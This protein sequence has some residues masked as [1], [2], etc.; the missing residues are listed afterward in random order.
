MP[1]RTWTP[2]RLAALALAAS[3][4]GC[5]CE[6]QYAEFVSEGDG[7]PNTLPLWPLS[8]STLYP[9]A[10]GDRPDH[11]QRPL[12]ISQRPT[13]QG[14]RFVLDYPLSFAESWPALPQWRL[15]RDTVE[16][17]QL[18]SGGLVAVEPDGRRYLLVPGKAR[19][20]MRW[21][22]ELPALAGAT[23]L[24]LCHPGSAAQ[25]RH[26]AGVWTFEVLSRQEV[27]GPAG[28][29]VAW[30]IGALGPQVPH[31]DKNGTVDDG[32]CDTL[33]WR[34]T[35]SAKASEVP[36]RGQ[37]LLFYEGVGP[38]SFATLDEGGG[39]APATAT[40]PAEAFATDA[41]AAPTLPPRLPVPSGVTA[42][43]GRAA[44]PLP[45]I[46]L[47]D[48]G[49]PPATSAPALFRP[50]TARLTWSS[51]EVAAGHGAELMLSGVT[52]GFAGELDPNGNLQGDPVPVRVPLCFA[53]DPT[54]PKH[55]PVDRLA[56]PCP[57][58]HP[59][60]S[61]SSEYFK[62]QPYV[63]P[64]GTWWSRVDIERLAWR[65]GSSA[66]YLVGA[67]TQAPFVRNGVLHTLN[68]HGDLPT[69]P[70]EL[71]AFP[72]DPPPW[73]WKATETGVIQG[74]VVWAHVEPHEVPRRGEGSG[75]EAAVPPRASLRYA[76]A[77]DTGFIHA[78]VATLPANWRIS[79]FEPGVARDSAHR[80]LIVRWFSLDGRLL[81]YRA[82]PV[83]Q[84]GLTHVDGRYRLVDARPLGELL[85]YELT[86]RG[87]RVL[88]RGRLGLGDGERAEHALALAD[89]RFLVVTSRPRG[90]GQQIGL[91]LAATLRWATQ[92]ASA[93][94]GI[95]AVPDSLTRDLRFSVT[96]PVTGPA[97]VDVVSAGHGLA[98]WVTGR[99]LTLCDAP[100][101]EPPL[102]VDRLRVGELDVD[103]SMRAR[104]AHGC[105][106][107]AVPEPLLEAVLGAE[108]SGLLPI[109][110]T[111]RSVGT[112]RRSVAVART[113]AAPPPAMIPT[114]P[115]PD[116]RAPRST[117][118][119]ASNLVCTG[120]VAGPPERPGPLIPF[121][122]TTCSYP[123][124]GGSSLGNP[125]GGVDACD[126]SAGPCL[127]LLAFD[128]PAS[129]PAT[130]EWLVSDPE[131]PYL[132]ARPDLFPAG[133]VYL[134]PRSRA[135]G[136]LIARDFE[137][138]RPIGAQGRHWQVTPDAQSWRVPDG[139]G[140][141]PGIDGTWPAELGTPVVEAR[142]FDAAALLAG[143]GLA[144]L[145][146]PAQTWSG[147]GRQLSLFGPPLSQW[148]LLTAEPTAHGAA[149]RWRHGPLPS[150]D[151]RALG[152][153]G[154]VVLWTTGELTALS[155]GACLS[156][157]ETCNGLDDDC[158][159]EVDETGADGCPDPDAVKACRE[160]VCFRTACVAG[161]AACGASP[162]RCD[163]SLGTEANCRACGDACPATSGSRCSP[164]GCTSAGATRFAVTSLYR[165]L[166]TTDGSVY[167][168]PQG[169][170]WATTK[171]LLGTFADVATGPS[172]VCTL[173][174][175]GQVDCTC[176]GSGW[177][178][179]Q[180]AFGASA[181]PAGVDRVWAGPSSTCVRVAGSGAVTC[182]GAALSDGVTAGPPT[183]V[184]ALTGAEQVV[185]S[186]AEGS[187]R[188]YALVGGAVL[189]FG[190]TSTSLEVTPVVGLPTVTSLRA[191]TGYVLFK[192]AMGWFGLGP[193][194]RYPMLAGPSTGP[195]TTPTRAMG[196][197]DA[198]GV[199]AGFGNAPCALKPGQIRCAFEPGNPPDRTRYTFDAPAVV[200]SNGGAIDL[201]VTYQAA[202]ALQSTIC[203]VREDQ[204]ASVV[205]RP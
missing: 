83:W 9:I 191:A 31:V 178:S 111:V 44:E 129:I 102:L 138:A 200:D 127:D 85:E 56:L 48:L 52:L 125:D 16:L 158:D 195:W 144:T 103:V 76:I 73:L 106:Q 135:A 108:A 45:V 147:P 95:P 197:D 87:V 35:T 176:E 65:S 49:A 153:D 51:S 32:S 101:A 133:R 165:Y 29:T 203:V 159:G 137:T 117:R 78:S 136:P 148:L 192:T 30:R 28:P 175:A 25:A 151:A 13:E 100:G 86:P 182:W 134:I 154:N 131:R 177:Q 5:S 58:R 180:G 72:T 75:T 185:F 167:R 20:G 8:P 201:A 168:S 152:T 150:P 47:T 80:A 181:G 22:V 120:S 126:P 146:S 60:G 88:K 53:F 114:L 93:Y 205:C 1:L 169:T 121:S 149:P 15:F 198:D 33:W 97:T 82:I 84:P 46:T 190:R 164:A 23:D 202:S 37:V 112:F 109:A 66:N 81:D 98:A 115:K 186:Q 170:D 12:V 124:W 142:P 67:H 96:A 90:N 77:H 161:R 10:L 107:V 174:A 99:T 118:P 59:P 204:A 128:G 17:L 64:D 145:P 69:D 55:L 160:G 139:A 119:P 143:T 62:A 71:L 57:D 104:D 61:L 41:G 38:F 74:L 94:G 70:C 34:D 183:S 36:R 42:L 155:E 132:P 187:W 194:H 79:D 27:S 163:T 19:V 54:A 123:L 2:T 196:L 4:V 40:R 18:P 39:A 171:T 3:L 63:R 43:A 50:R 130:H 199:I 24:D 26:G 189:R 14:Q 11:W 113:A 116:D 105:H 141:R 68:C 179:C 21:R 184:P 7:P 173:D 89:D 91:K 166:R 6:Q 140:A 188:G 156:Q 110:Y 193:L 162:G 172:H 122:L 92:N 157:A